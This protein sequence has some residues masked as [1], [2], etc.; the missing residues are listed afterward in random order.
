MGIK[1]TKHDIGG[2]LIS[3]LTRGM[4][5]DP[6][7]T[8]REYVQ[9]GVDANAKNIEIKIRGNSIVVEDDGDGMDEETILKAIRVGISDKN[10]KNDVGFRGI[11]IYSSFHLCDQLH[12]YSKAQGD[13]PHLLTFNFD[14]MREI[15]DQQQ[16]DRLKGHLTGDDLVDLQSLLERYIEYKT[17]K[18]DEFLKETGTRVEMVNLDPSFFKSLSKFEEVADYIRQ[19][20]PLHFDPDK[21]KYTQKIENEITKLCKDHKAGF[22]LIDLTLQVD[23]R[24][25]KLYR[26]Y[27]NELFD[28]EPLSPRFRAVKYKN[29]FF[30]VAWGC[31]NS[32]RRK[33]ND[34]KLRG[35][36]IRKQGFAIGTRSDVAKYFG[37]TTYFDR[38]IGEIIIVHPDLLPNAARADL[39][40]S[41]LRASFYEALTDVATFYNERANE[42]Q[43]FT[44]GDDELNEAVE[45]LKQLEASISFQSENLEQLIDS[46]VKVRDIRERIKGRL[47]RKALREEK[48]D[49]AKKIVKS[50]E[51][52]EKAIQSFINQRRKGTKTKKGKTPETKSQERVKELPETKPKEE[53]NLPE[54]LSEVFEI[55]GLSVS[56]DIKKALEIIDEKF[57]QAS[58]PNKT[59]YLLAL[60][61]LKDELEDIIDNG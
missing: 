32:T 26:P 47:K 61:N 1:I 27:T 55:L 38:Y 3:I 50:A 11:G 16:K 8:L 13:V 31:L 53:E 10:P 56:K 37:R 5:P 20:V 52:L 18:P 17:I 34:K 36:L 23:S 19:V 57:I 58:T 60:K 6:R 46:I 54:S 7:D 29:H 44:K 15:L 42:Y 14:R 45:D 39:E 51:A 48:K 28:K 33:I 49:D 30:G 25:E 22:S 24:V 35:F 43:E 41:P 9:N 12:I 2:D 40:M 21:F 4:Y 59:E